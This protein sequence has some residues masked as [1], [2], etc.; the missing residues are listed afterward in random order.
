MAKN[1][2]K[3]AVNEKQNDVIEE[4]APVE[5]EQEVYEPV[6][7]DQQV[8]VKSIAGWTVGFTRLTGVGDVSIPKYGSTRLSR[9]EII[10]QSQNGNRLLNGVEGQDN[11]DHATLIIQDDIT[12]KEL[13]FENA[14]V[15]SDKVVKDLFE[16]GDIESFE[17]ELRN[18]IVTRAEKYALMVS[19]A[20]QKLND[21]AKIRIAEEYS[22]FS[23]DNIVKDEKNIR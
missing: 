9:L 6:N 15:F 19:I 1:T 12:R 14:K 2:T 7:L 13:G 23:M 4:A 16:I 18:T 17:I 21:Y 10:S 22:G 20:R 8:T 3:K 5:V 11:G